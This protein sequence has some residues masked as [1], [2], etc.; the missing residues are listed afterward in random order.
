V[1]F[2]PAFQP[3]ARERLVIRPPAPEDAASLLA[4]ELANRAWFERWVHPR[5]PDFYRLEAIEAAIARAAE[6]RRADRGYQY[7]A[8]G[9]DGRIVGGVNL[10][11]VRRQHHRSAELGFHVG[12]RETG[13][14]FASA[15]VAWCLREAFGPLDLWRLEATVRPVNL[16]SI[17]VLEHNGF[18]AW[19]RST[20]CIEFD[21]E[22]SDLIHFER[23]A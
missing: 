5:D 9:A 19:G 4:F 20:R 7:L 12:E 22:W 14:G 15:A 13:R 21:G 8:F 23:H 1:A 2:V 16:A 11:D 6:A 10:R 3:V 17:R 18:V